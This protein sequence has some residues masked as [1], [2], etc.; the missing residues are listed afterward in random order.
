MSGM[1]FILANESARL[2]AIEAIKNAPE[3]Y[4]VSIKEKTRTG[5]QNA[6]LWP[7]LRDVSS[8]VDWH[9]YKLADDEWKDVFSAAIKKQK[10]VPGLCGGFVVCGQSTSK[11]GKK[12]FSE[13]L[14][15]IMA[16]GA[17]HDVVFK[18]MPTINA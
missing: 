5:E 11:M 6:L 17:E 9:G 7:L 8:Q 18:E 3:G 1:Y 16:F 13:M 15:L 14:E 12:M 10:V 4:E 2:R